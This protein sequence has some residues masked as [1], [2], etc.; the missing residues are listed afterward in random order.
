MGIGGVSSIS[1]RVL[2]GSAGRRWR[3]GGRAGCVLHHFGLPASAAV[4]SAP[5]CPRPVTVAAV[6]EG[7]SRKESVMALE[8]EGP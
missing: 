5:A 1:L 7:P 8:K 6:G 4:L 3:D 2:G